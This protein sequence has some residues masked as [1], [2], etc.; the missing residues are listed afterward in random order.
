LDKKI[1]D[2]QSQHWERN[3]LSK[4]EMFGLEPSVAA[5]K[6]FKL[7]KVT[8]KKKNKSIFL[9]QKLSKYHYCNTF[10]L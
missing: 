1:L 10:F 6:S 4:P 2:K 9:A 5:V 3:F 7:F 8:L